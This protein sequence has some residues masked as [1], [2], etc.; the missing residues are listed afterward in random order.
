MSEKR[1]F[2]D[3]VCHQWDQMCEHDAGKIRSLLGYLDMSPGDKIL[4]VGTGTGVLIPFIREINARGKILGI[5]NSSGMISVAREKF[6]ADKF[7]NFCIADIER[8]VIEGIFDHIILYS[9]FPHLQRKSET[10]RRLVR[11][12]LKEG[13]RLLIAHSQSRNELNKMHKNIDERVASDVLIEVN[14][15]C[16]IFRAFGLSVYEAVENDD[17]YMIMLEK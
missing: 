5:D 13:G 15:Q 7:T 16:R 10:M 11:K 3:S 4:D 9:V 6:K 1:Y 12:N 8:D 17:F 14:E 2:F